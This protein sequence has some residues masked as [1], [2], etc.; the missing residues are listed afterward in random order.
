MT[1]ISADNHEI[2][3]HDVCHEMMLF[4]AKAQGFLCCLAH[5]LVVTVGIVYLVKEIGL[6]LH[7]CIPLTFSNLCVCACVCVCVCVCV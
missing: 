7:I 3:N 2:I 6:S 4:F 5:F 1:E